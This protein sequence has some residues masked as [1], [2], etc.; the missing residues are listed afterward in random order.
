MAL[1]HV[2][3]AIAHPAMRDKAMALKAAIEKLP[4]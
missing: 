4:N 2:D 1:T 3:V